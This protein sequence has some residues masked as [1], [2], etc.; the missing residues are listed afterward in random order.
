MNIVLCT[1]VHIQIH[2]DSVKKCIQTSTKM[3]WVIQSFNSFFGFWFIEGFFFLGLFTFKHG[4]PTH[5][6]DKA[7]KCKVSGITREIAGRSY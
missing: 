2:T 6:E 4:I 5:G 7:E 3:H 1:Y